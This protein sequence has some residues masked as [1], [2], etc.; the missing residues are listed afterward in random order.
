MK[1]NNN[2]VRLPHANI[3]AAGSILALVV[4]EEFAV[5]DDNVENTVPF[6]IAHDGI[7][8]RFYGVKTSLSKTNET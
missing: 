8:F 7:K 3:D 4:V 1:I 5:V 6:K 2:D